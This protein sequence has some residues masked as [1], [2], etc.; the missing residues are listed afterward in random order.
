[1]LLILKNIEFF[2]MNWLCVF[3]FVV[4]FVVCV[5]GVGVDLIIKYCKIKDCEN[6]GLF[7]IDYV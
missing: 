7:V 3:L 4:G 1:M 2:V 6:V 5:L